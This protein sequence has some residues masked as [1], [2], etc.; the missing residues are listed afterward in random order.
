MSASSSTGNR[1]PESV[2]PGEVLSTIDW[3]TWLR[4]EEIKGTEALLRFNGLKVTRVER[5]F[6]DDGT[7][8]EEPVVIH[9]DDGSQVLFS[10]S[11]CCCGRLRILYIARTEGQSAKDHAE[12]SAK[13]KP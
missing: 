4:S 8:D 13:E 11:C 3:D 10:A 1:E 7:G 5:K 12:E 6:Y 2:R 9:F